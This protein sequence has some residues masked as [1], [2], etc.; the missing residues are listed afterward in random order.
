[1]EKV[2][3]KDFM[4]FVDYAHEPKSLEYLLKEAKSFAKGRII[5]LTGSAGGGRDRQKRE[6]MGAV[7]DKYADIVIVANEDPYDEDPQK[8]IE[9]VA[10]GVKDK[11]LGKT[12]F[13]ELDRK[14]AIALALSLAEKG[15]VVLIAG[16]GAEVTIMSKE[17][18]VPHNDKEEVL[19]TLNK[20]G[21]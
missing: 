3:D 19:K 10:R 14:K 12:L 18:P 20:I 4:V 9:D 15:D 7:A 21:V 13:K 6:K 1:M 17:G 16:K 2:Y 5:L 8:I 11:I